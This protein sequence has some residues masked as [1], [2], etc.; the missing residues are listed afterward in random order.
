MNH[1][2]I[3]RLLLEIID[4]KAHLKNLYTQLFDEMDIPTSVEINLPDLPQSI[5]PGIYRCPT[6]FPWAQVTYDGRKGMA[7]KASEVNHLDNIIHGNFK[8]ETT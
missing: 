8:R 6:G 3:Q 4:T 5:D 7:W 1:Q 2:E